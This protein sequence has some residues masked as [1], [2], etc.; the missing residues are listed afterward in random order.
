LEKLVFLTVFEKGDKS[1]MH[2]RIVRNT[3]AMADQ[4]CTGKIYIAC[5]RTGKVKGDIK[6]GQPWSHRKSRKLLLPLGGG[7]RILQRLKPIPLQR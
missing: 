6:T 4:N 5:I 3:D 2:M 1:I 7:I